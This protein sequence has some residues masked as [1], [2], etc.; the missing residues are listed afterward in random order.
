M[1]VVLIT[2]PI[3]D[4][5]SLIKFTKKTLNIEPTRGLDELKISP[6]EPV[7]LPIS[8]GLDNL[9]KKYIYDIN[10]YGW[11][12]YNLT[13]IV[14]CD[15]VILQTL[16]G[17]EFNINIISEKRNKIVFV[18]TGS[19]KDFY[20]SIILQCNPNNDYESRLLFNR[21]FEVLNSSN[22][23]KLFEKNIIKEL[24]DNTFIIL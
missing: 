13:F 12:H 1:E 9:Q 11:Q 4:W 2:T 18:I 6:K 3:V 17:S 10:F 22:I 15:Y 24:E 16:L 14:N 20:D 7:A 21:F 23:K 5:E 8:L 19:I